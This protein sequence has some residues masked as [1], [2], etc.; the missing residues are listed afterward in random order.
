MGAQQSTVDTAL[1]LFS[2][3]AENK[4]ITYETKQL[5]Q[6]LDHILSE[7]HDFNQRDKSGSTLLIYTAWFAGILE[8]EQYIEPLIRLGADVNLQNNDG[9]SA[10]M[11]AAEFAT[12][13]STERTSKLLLVANTWVDLQDTNGNSALILAT[14][15]TA[16]SS[17]NHIVRLLLNAQSNTNLQN[18]TGSTA[19]MCAIAKAETTSTPET[20]SLILDY[21]PNINLQNHIGWSAI[22][23]VSIID[24]VDLARQIVHQLR[25]RG[26]RLDV[27]ND[28]N[29]T[30][31]DLLNSIMFDSSIV[32]PS[33]NV[34]MHKED[35]VRQ[36]SECVACHDKSSTIITLPCAHCCLC[37]ECF[38]KTCRTKCV[39]CNHTITDHLLI[40]QSDI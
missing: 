15:K 24:D 27:K 2:T 11:L 29:Q 21:K 10:L 17:S 26:A 5:P 12:T 35:K 32:F 37:E 22:M 6:I 36:T 8:L 13:L 9:K 4:I 25:D 28:E 31:N 20:V 1:Y 40:I 33:L 34:S 30:V 38:D 19:L 7:E 3:Y 14:Q 39:V 23:Y 16:I 18:R